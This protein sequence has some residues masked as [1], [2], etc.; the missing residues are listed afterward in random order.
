MISHIPLSP[1]AET[2]FVVP[3][4]Y[5]GPLDGARGQT[6]DGRTSGL[7]GSIPKHGG[8]YSL[9]GFYLPEG[10]PEAIRP[11]ASTLAVYLWEAG[12]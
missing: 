6:I 9:Q 2:P 7:K 5:G 12:G 1:T 11:W 4:Y 10:Y 3:A 8:V